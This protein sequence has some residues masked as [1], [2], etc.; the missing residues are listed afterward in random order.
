MAPKP[1]T[2]TTPIAGLDQLPEGAQ[3][4]VLS[5]TNYRQLSIE[6]LA[7]AIAQAAG[8]RYFG[9]DTYP[10]KEF[11]IDFAK[12]LPEIYRLA[13]TPPKDSDM[14]RGY[15]I[16]DVDLRP[17]LSNYAQRSETSPA[18]RTLA[19]SEIGKVAERYSMAFNEQGT[20]GAEV[21]KNFETNSM[22][23]S[24]STYII[25]TAIQGEGGADTAVSED[26][27][28]ALASEGMQ[29]PDFQGSS[30]TGLVTQENQVTEF[31]LD[32]TRTINDLAA[33]LEARGGEYLFNLDGFY[34]PASGPDGESGWDP[35]RTALYPYELDSKKLTDL[36]SSLAQAGYFERLNMV[37]RYGE[38]DEATQMAWALMLRDSI[39]Q[40]KTPANMLKT[41]IQ[42]RNLQT[43]RPMY[44]V[45]YWDEAKIFDTAQSAGVSLLGRGLTENELESLT[46]MFRSWERE[47][48]S[49]D[50]RAQDPEATQVD[51]EAR[52]NEYLRNQFQADY[53]TES[54]VSSIGNL[55]KAWM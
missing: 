39:V 42:N 4:L 5:G 7:G 9:G 48:A 16:A 1:T 22:G 49:Q 38:K 35:K 19:Q 36:Q 55:G 47:L 52:T 50:W 11:F 25:E 10:D 40:Q 34:M 12:S 45:P 28:S 8:R 18:F 54:I 27:Q 21:F 17:L 13:Y 6:N 3:K 41:A 51:L 24:P 43:S 30:G 23:L 37:P 20:A 32:A 29:I 31:R 15:V 26:A 14:V 2:G 53:L 33:D 44:G 46:T